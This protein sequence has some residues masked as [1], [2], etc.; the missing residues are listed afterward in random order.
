MESTQ[1]SPLIR[2][3]TCELRMKLQTDAQKASDFKTNLE[4]TTLVLRQAT[5]EFPVLQRTT[6]LF[7]KGQHSSNV[8]RDRPFILHCIF[9]KENHPFQS[10]GKMQ[11]N[12]VTFITRCDTVL[13]RMLLHHAMHEMKAFCILQVPARA[14]NNIVFFGG[15]CHQL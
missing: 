14:H 6:S 3:K 12:R 9:C 15:N 5:T 2:I 8:Q 11:V 4:G 10:A 13:L 1:L 7:F